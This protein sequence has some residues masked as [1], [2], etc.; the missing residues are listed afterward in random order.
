VRVVVSSNLTPCPLPER[1][2]GSY[3][4]VLGPRSPVPCSENSPISLPVVLGRRSTANCA[5][6]PVPQC[7]LDKARRLLGSGAKLVAEA[8]S[9][10]RE[11][12]GGSS[13]DGSY[14]S[15]R[16]TPGSWRRLAWRRRPPA[17]R[18]PPWTRW[19]Q[20]WAREGSGRQGAGAHRGLAE[21]GDAPVRGCGPG[22]RAGRLGGRPAFVVAGRGG[23]AGRALRHFPGPRPPQPTSFREAVTLLISTVLGHR[24]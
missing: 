1:E 7:G 19:W 24:G 5:L 18:P 3:V 4:F 22:G 21:L 16:R 11:Q 6:C 23:R 9:D 17:F 12:R 20:R 13:W 14:A 15:P 2:G 10:R 8:I